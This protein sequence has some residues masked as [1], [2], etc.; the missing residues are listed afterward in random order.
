P[1]QLH[2][3]ADDLDGTVAGYSWVATGPQGQS[4]VL[5]AVANPGFE[6][7][8]PGVW[9]VRLA[10]SDDQGADSAAVLSIRVRNR[11]PVAAPT[12]TPAITPRNTPVQ[13]AAGA[14]D[15]DGWIT[16]HEW[17]RSG[18]GSSWSPAG[19]EANPQMSFAEPGI[20]RAYVVVHDNDGG[21][22]TAAALID[23]R[24][25]RPNT[26]PLAVTYP[27]AKGYA[28]DDESVHLSMAGATDPDGDPL[29][30]SLSGG[31]EGTF[32]G[33][34]GVH[35]VSGT[36]TD[37]YGDTATAT[38]SVEIKDKVEG[39]TNSAASNFAPAANYDDGSCVFTTY[40]CTATTTRP[41]EG[42]ATIGWSLSYESLDPD[43]LSAVVSAG[44][45][46]AG[47][48]WDCPNSQDIF[49][50]FG[51]GGAISWSFENGAPGQG[52]QSG[53]GEPNGFSYAAP[54]PTAWHIKLP[55]PPNRTDPWT[56][57]WS[58]EVAEGIIMGSRDR[59]SVTFSC[60]LR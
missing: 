16:G 44:K 48:S 14:S 36:V 58:A 57:T 1:I 33:A 9:T 20:Y 19:N 23:V 8:R 40:Q 37:P 13:L 52:D 60:A 42:L 21:V 10:V 30:G 31:M 26:P 54:N 43:N 17:F 34:P 49:W 55:S 22:D 53:T 3:N 5:D 12:A 47:E 51:S 39:C 35:L 46:C 45:A 4:V 27:G 15:R 28:W 38:A 56:F 6:A 32:T 50:V 2:A 11:A 7:P 41:E 18:P 59:Q 24:N 29:T 25:R